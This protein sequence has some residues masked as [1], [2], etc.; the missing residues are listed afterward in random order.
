MV[1]TADYKPG[2]HV[3]MTSGRHGG[4]ALLLVSALARTG[5]CIPGFFFSF[6]FDV[7]TPLQR[8]ASL[9]ESES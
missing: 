1:D 3:W 9:S 7:V 5:S 2:I 6:R 4:F 8:V